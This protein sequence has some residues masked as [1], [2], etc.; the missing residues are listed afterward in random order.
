MKISVFG[1]LTKSPEERMTADGKT[2][3]YLSIAED[4]KFAKDKTTDF[5]NITCFGKTAEYVAKHLEKGN[6]ILI[7]G[8]CQNNNYEGKNGKKVYGFSFLAN[9]ITDFFDW[10]TNGSATADTEES[11][12]SKDTSEYYPAEEE[13]GIPF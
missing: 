12:D 4:R 9:E 5:F 7:D 3:T 11:S 6:R 8:V 13:N 2:V 1:R 10:K